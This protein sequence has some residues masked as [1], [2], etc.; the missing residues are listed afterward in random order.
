MPSLQVC[1]QSATTSQP[2]R[3]GRRHVVLQGLLRAIRLR[4]YLVGL[5]SDSETE[6]DV[7]GRAT[8][9]NNLPPLHIM[10]TVVTPRCLAVVAGLCPSLC[11]RSQRCGRCL[12]VRP[13]PCEASEI[14]LLTVQAL[15]ASVNVMQG[16]LVVSTMRGGAAF[17]H[18]RSAGWCN[19]VT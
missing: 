5:T 9:T 17:R 8:G 12:S 6:S 4:H 19:G 13:T 3:A 10:R 16:S 18:A 15:V 2:L 7:C 11:C 14:I 1:A